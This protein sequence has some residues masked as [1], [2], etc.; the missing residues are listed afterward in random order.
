[1]ATAPFTAPLVLPR[2]LTKSIVKECAVNF[3]SDSKVD[4][5]C[6]RMLGVV[7]TLVPS[8]VTPLVPDSA[9]SNGVEKSILVCFRQFSGDTSS[10]HFVRLRELI[11]A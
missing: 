8:S 11:R 6:R 3:L 2:G 10:I 1:M 9:P 4:V 5:E 7:E